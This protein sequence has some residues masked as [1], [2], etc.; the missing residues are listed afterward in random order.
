MFGKHRLTVTTL[1]LILSILLLSMTGD[2]LPFV[3]RFGDLNKERTGFAQ[4]E[5]I[6]V[7]S[8][9]TLMEGTP[10]ETVLYIIASPREGPTVMV[11]GGIH[12]DEPAGYLAADSIASWAI[13]RGTLLVLPRANVPAIVD[14][15]RIA[16]GG[17]DLNRTFPGD[18]HGNQT[19]VLAFEIF[20]LIEEFKPCWVLDLHEA[21][22]FERFARGSLGQ[23]LIYPHEGE[24]LDIV[25]ELL[26]AVNRT[27]YSEEYHFLLLRG[28]A[29]G[30]LIEAVYLHN[31]E[32]I[33]LETCMKMPVETRIKYQRQI[34]ASMLY[35]LGISVY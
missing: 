18:P 7:S 1:L 3:G 16:P 34:V 17:S 10:W 33:I 2:G 28:A 19:E 25:K 14:R 13:D 15:K 6:S 21:E 30:S 9:R 12:G 29:H 8:E 4:P 31:A 32:A 26:T 11:I 24:S 23:T 27:I 22:D 35:L 5:A 20:S